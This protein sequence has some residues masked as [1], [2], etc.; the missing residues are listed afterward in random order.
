MRG[1]EAVDYRVKFV[2]SFLFA[3]SHLRSYILKSILVY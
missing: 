1:R 2:F 3:L